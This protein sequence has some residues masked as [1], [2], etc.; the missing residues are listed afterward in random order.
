MWGELTTSWWPS[1][2]SHDL[3]FQPWAVSAELLG[4]LWGSGVGVGRGMMLGRAWIRV[5]GGGRCEGG[6]WCVQGPWPPLRGGPTGR[7][8]LQAASTLGRGIPGL[9]G[10]AKGS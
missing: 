9:I 10:S 4:P 2:Q 6:H 5:C 1:G 7:P 8:A 3:P